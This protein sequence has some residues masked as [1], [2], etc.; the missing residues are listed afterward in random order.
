MLTSTV[1]ETV[2]IYVKY[3]IIQFT[4]SLSKS[5]EELRSGKEKTKLD[6]QDSENVTSH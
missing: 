1:S 5:L 6:M 2:S 4:C 3:D